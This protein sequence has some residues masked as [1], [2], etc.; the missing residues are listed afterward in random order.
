LLLLLV[1]LLLLLLC[2]GLQQR[3]CGG[4]HMRLSCT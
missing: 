4:V 3:P 1:L 2:L